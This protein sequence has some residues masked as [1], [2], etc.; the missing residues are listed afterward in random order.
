MV[1]FLFCLFFENY[2]KKEKMFDDI[3]DSLILYKEIKKDIDKE[4]KSKDSD[5]LDNGVEKTY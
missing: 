4:K 1:G 2:V 5:L 3:Y